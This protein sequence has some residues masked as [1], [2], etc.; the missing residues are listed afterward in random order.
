MEQIERKSLDNEQFLQLRQATDKIAKSLDGRLKGH[1]SVLRSLFTPKKFLG[2][3]IK[4]AAPTEVAG[5]D[6]VFTLL[7]ERYAAVCEKP[8]G[9]PKR[10]HPPLNELSGQMEGTPYTYAIQI[11]HK[12]T[13]VLSPTR[14]ILSFR[15]ECS[16][17][18][19]ASMLGGAESRQ[20]EAMKQT[21]LSHLML[22]IILE[23]NKELS[24]LLQD[25]RYQIEI[26]P[27]Q[28]FGGLPVVLLKAPIRTFLPPDDFITH[29][30]QLSGVP[31]F[32]E[33]IDLDTITQMPDPLRETLK[34]LS[35]A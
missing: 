22:V 17:D 35:P 9:L 5:A 12:N 18:R 34:P 28:E 8:F 1:M 19:L 13:K 21:L 23:H 30:T 32:Q 33:L 29:I 24:A 2:T 26:Q 3:F 16:L 10:L 27:L 25:L 15:T 4:S 11:D 31:A 14:W 6:R 7:Q 20:P